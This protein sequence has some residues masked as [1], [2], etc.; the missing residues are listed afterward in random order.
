MS[1]FSS[2]SFH[3]DNKYKFD[4]RPHHTEPP[5]SHNTNFSSDKEKLCLVFRYAILFRRTHPC[6]LLKLALRIC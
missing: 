5:I 2:Y 3:K 4:D 1:S 6:Q